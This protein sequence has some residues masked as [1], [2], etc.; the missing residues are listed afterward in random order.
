MTARLFT[1]HNALILSSIF[2]F[3]M[4]C[5]LCKYLSIKVPRKFAGQKP[6]FDTSES[7]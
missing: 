2:D 6:D 7:S 4:K 5:A 1:I 3:V